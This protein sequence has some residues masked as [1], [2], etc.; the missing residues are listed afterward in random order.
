[1][2]RMQ[3]RQR[4]IES[5]AERVASWWNG[6]PA[7]LAVALLFAVMAVSAARGTSP[8][9]D[10]V[11]HITAGTSYLLF[12]DHRLQPENGLL[13]QLLEGLPGW[14]D[15]PARFP[16][17]DSAEWAGSDVWRL[18]DLYF[19]GPRGDGQA[20]RSLLLSARALVAAVA[21]ALGLLVY[22]WARKL[23]GPSG[24]MLALLLYAFSPTL[25]SHGALATSDLC[26]AAAFLLAVLAVSAVLERCTALRTLGAGAALTVLFLC[27]GS[28]L[29]VLP[30]TG[31]MLVLRLLRRQPLP[32]G[33]IAATRLLRGRAQALVVLLALPVALALIV[34][35]GLWAGYGFRY[36]VH[37]ADAS[38]PQSLYW[39]GWPHI[40]A[41]RSPGV[42]AVLW[43]R[44]RHALPEPWLYGLGFVLAHST[45]RDAFL[46]GEYSPD[47]FRSFFPR[48][49]LYKTPPAELLLLGLAAAAGLSRSARRR[50]GNAADVRD[51]A[52]EP[53]ARDHGASEGAAC[54]STAFRAAPLWLLIVVV[55]AAAL[56]S[57]LNIGHRHLLP[58]YPAAFI[59]AGAA[60]DWLARPP[61]GMAALVL[62][63]LGW[64]VLDSLAIRPHYLAYFSPLAGGP[65]QGYRHLVDSSLDWGQDLP[66]LAAYVAQQRASS[67]PPEEVYVSYFGNGRLTAEGLVA[68]ELPC[69]PDRHRRA[70]SYPL[71]PGLYCL[72]A[73]M[74]QN[75]YFALKPPWTAQDETQWQACRADIERLEAAQSD[76]AAF[77]AA[78]AERGEAAWNRRMHDYES[79]RFAR[80]CAFLRAREP[81]AQ[82]GYSILVYRLSAE[83]A[84]AA[85]YGPAPTR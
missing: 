42:R 49:A 15:G 83:E 72:S 77:A 2:G 34:W 38:P 12:G 69:E 76:A 3:H 47:G 58:L 55:G 81:D 84:A 48:A 32:V 7:A 16:G 78:I 37:A 13:P 36:P 26:A 18:A 30:V 27:K 46:D 52:S 11:G 23:N 71:G 80:L 28:A 25:L 45:G 73:T 62:A 31:A 67:A 70:E 10:E 59:L 50:D 79:L 75:V 54:E 1:M 40:E 4:T 33:W 51:A 21:A 35:A 63:A 20:W 65:S 66:G 14:S 24:G 44:D 64:Q 57:R 9:Y 60:A 19:Y 6:A 39:G 82:I 43:L 17:R 85:V 74:L 53:A 68:R 61:R 5:G 8:V 41:V 22:A 29:L 56:T